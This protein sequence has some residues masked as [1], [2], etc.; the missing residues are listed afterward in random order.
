M[1][2][3]AIA[4]SL[5]GIGH[6]EA[7]IGV[8]A[9]PEPLQPAARGE[10]RPMN[11]QRTPHRPAYAGAGCGQALPPYSFNR[12]CAAQSNSHSAFTFANPRS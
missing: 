7:W 9:A 11:D 5:C 10:R 12:L 6:I 3:G 8:E 1:R 2:P 4:R